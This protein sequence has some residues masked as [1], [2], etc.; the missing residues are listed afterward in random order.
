M[1]AIIKVYFYMSA[2]ALAKAD[3]SNKVLS[4][5][6]STYAKASAESSKK[7][8]NTDPACNIAEGL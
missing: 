4:K 6:K 8:K 7:R 2:V 3:V 1:A 5:M